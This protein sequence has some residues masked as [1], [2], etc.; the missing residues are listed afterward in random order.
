MK[1][2]KL[3]LM[4]PVYFIGLLIVI[5]LFTVLNK[6]FWDSRIRHLCAT[7]GGVTVFETVDLKDP[8]Y[9]RIPIAS[10][11]RPLIP[12][13]SDMAPEDPLYRSSISVYEQK[14]GGISIERSELSIVRKIDGKTVSQ[15][16]TFIRRDGDFTT[17][18]SP[19]SGFS[20]ED[21]SG[22]P[23]ELLDQTFNLQGE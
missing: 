19:G 11:G 21:I 10:N 16:V 15:R 22:L 17:L 14:F 1:H 23:L 8:A 13:A 6:A 3:L 9:R 5:F 18:G 2:V 12:L 4:L 7:D 20:C